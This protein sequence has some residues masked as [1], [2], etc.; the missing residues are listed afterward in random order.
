VAIQE[1][2]PPRSIPRAILQLGAL[3]GSATTIGE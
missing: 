2:V 1:M 3:T